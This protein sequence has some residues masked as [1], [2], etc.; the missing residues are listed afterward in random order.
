MPRHIYLDTAIVLPRLWY[1]DPDRRDYAGKIIGALQGQLSRHDDFSV[2]IPQL[3]VGEAAARY[4][5][6]NEN[7][8]LK[9]GAELPNDNFLGDLNSILE[10]TGGEL[11]SS[12]TES[13]EI[14]KVLERNDSRVADNDAL[15]L[16]T[17]F[18][19]PFATHLLTTDR[20]LINTEALNTAE[21]LVN[22]VHSFTVT[23]KYG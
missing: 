11:V 12:N 19:D 21:R 20:A 7:G 17:A 8:T 16:A 13:H 22:R 5:E 15:I 14:A 4:L 1:Q 6:E 9:R 3:C 2:K 23:D 18:T 10:R